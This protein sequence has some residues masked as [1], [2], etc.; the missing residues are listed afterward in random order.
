ML[1]YLYY[2]NRKTGV[3]LP[4]AATLESSR[5]GTSK[6]GTSKESTNL[7]KYFTVDC[8][9]KVLQIRDLTEFP[10]EEW[11]MV[12]AKMDKIL[13][14]SDCIQNPCRCCTFKV[15]EEAADYAESNRCANVAVSGQI[16][17]TECAGNPTESWGF[18]EQSISLELTLRP[19]RPIIQ[20]QESLTLFAD[21]Y[22]I[23]GIEIEDY[24][25]AAES[26]DPQLLTVTSMGA[27]MFIL[28]RS[29]ELT[30]EAIVEV[31][32]GCNIKKSLTIKVGCPIPDL[33]GKWN[34]STKQRVWGCAAPENDGIYSLS[35]QEII[36]SH[37]A[38]NI[39]GG[40][41]F[42]TDEDESFYEEIAW[43]IEP[44]CSGHNEC[45]YTLKGRTNYLQQYYDPDSGEV[46]TVRGFS[47]CEGVL[48]NDDIMTVDFF[49]IDTE[50]DKCAH[51]GQETLQ[52]QTRP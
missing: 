17:Y 43:T 1:P 10:P 9:K 19:D 7:G 32:A 35:N 26:K 12:M 15:Q 45:T 47:D 5:P 25:V 28:E 38:E 21:V 36:L 23:N 14:H 51:R 4:D 48:T 18:E 44:K 41:I 42:L 49:G 37:L 34:L 30:G 24:E 50:G 29:S 2:L 31:D 40:S 13:T 33:T 16:Q 39:V 11:V 22:D 8:D 27:N 3:L 20:C 52:R 46:Y 6:F